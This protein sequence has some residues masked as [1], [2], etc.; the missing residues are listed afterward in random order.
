MNSGRKGMVWSCSVTGHKRGN[1]EEEEAEQLQ[2]VP[3]SHSR[4]GL[5]ATQAGEI[6]TFSSTPF[7]RP[8]PLP[9]PVPPSSQKS[10]SRPMGQAHKAP[11]SGSTRQV[12]ETWQGVGS[13]GFL[14][15]AHV[16]PAAEKAAC[17]I[18]ISKQEPSGTIWPET[19]VSDVS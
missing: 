8:A 19:N 15:S 2:P 11:P 12:A 13:Q 17:H 7:P 5:L 10:P 9:A 3:Q 16:G 4:Q 6:S 1:G 18:S 14:S